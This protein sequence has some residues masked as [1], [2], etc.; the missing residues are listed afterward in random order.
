MLPVENIL[1][2]KLTKNQNMIKDLVLS[3]S[4]ESLLVL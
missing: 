2:L 1:A 3:F 4:P